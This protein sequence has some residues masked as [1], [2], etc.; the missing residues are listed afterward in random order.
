MEIVPLIDW[1]VYEEPESA[2]VSSGKITKEQLDAVLVETSIELRVPISRYGK[3]CYIIEIEGPVTLSAL[4]HTVRNFY[5][6]KISDDARAR[7]EQVL[8]DDPVG[9]K[10]EFMKPENRGKTRFLDLIGSENHMDLSPA[11]ERRHPFSCNGMVRFEELSQRK[12]NSYSI[13]LG[14]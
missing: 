13:W 5:L 4:M 6:S 3:L 2:F 14:S 7:I 10:Q 11:G 8:D 12:G 9:Y 1:W